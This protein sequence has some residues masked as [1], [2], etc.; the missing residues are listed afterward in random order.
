MFVISC[1]GRP[2]SACSWSWMC[3]AAFACL[4]IWLCSFC[5]VLTFSC[6]VVRMLMFSFTRPSSASHYV[7]G[8]FFGT[9]CNLLAVMMVYKVRLLHLL[10][11]SANREQYWDSITKEDFEFSVGVKPNNWEVKEL[12]PEEERRATQYQ[13]ANSE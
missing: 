12:L 11:R 8:L 3:S 5:C 7:D 13:D 9:I 2:L 10:V 6:L 4:F 1:V